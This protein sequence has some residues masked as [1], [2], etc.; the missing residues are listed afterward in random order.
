MAKFFKTE[1]T[2]IIIIKMIGRIFAQII[3][4]KYAVGDKEHYD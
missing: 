4:Y 2:I 1:I 3:A